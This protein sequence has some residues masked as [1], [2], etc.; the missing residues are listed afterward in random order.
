[1]RNEIRSKRAIKTAFEDK[2]KGEKRDTSMPIDI[3]REPS[4]TA[5]V[6]GKNEW[7]RSVPTP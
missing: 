7:D 5:S 3:R 1:M 2:E 6:R 4:R